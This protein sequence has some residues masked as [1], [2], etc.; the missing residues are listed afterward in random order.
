M[1]HRVHLLL[2]LKYIVLDR[3]Q[4]LDKVYCTRTVPE[5]QKAMEELR[6][7]VSCYESEGIKLDLLAMSLSARPNLCINPC[8]TGGNRSEV[9]N[10]CRA[11]TATFVRKQNKESPRPDQLSC[12]FFEKL[13][14]R[15]IETII[16]RKIFNLEDLKDF[17]QD[18][19]ICPYFAA[20]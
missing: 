13:E 7:L 1:Y 19:G 2:Y 12:S 20:R 14:E 5:L 9:D 10:Q 11:R 17:G 6:D 4:N 3:L 16:P 15:P 8:V 18:E